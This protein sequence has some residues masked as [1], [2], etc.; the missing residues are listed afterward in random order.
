VVLKLETMPEN[1]KKNKMPLNKNSKMMI[2]NI[3]KENARE[4]SIIDHHKISAKV[5]KNQ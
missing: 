1:L 4:I 2:A 3:L 5:M